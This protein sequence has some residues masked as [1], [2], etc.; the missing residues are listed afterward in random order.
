MPVPS[1]LRKA[2]AAPAS[3]LGLAVVAL[4]LPLGAKLRLRKGVLEVC[5]HGPGSSHNARK[6]GR[7]LPFAAIT[8]GHVVIAASEADQDR[9]RL[10]ERVHVEQYE[11]WGAL[12]LLAY[13]SES[14]LQ[15]LLGRRAYL[16]NRFEVQARS[17]AARTH[18]GSSSSE[19]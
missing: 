6:P 19:A 8:F 11:R 16:D 4:L 5:L 12:F 7:R 17:R 2:W 14:L 3:A 9:L 1:L 10:H 18:D 13:P 15:H